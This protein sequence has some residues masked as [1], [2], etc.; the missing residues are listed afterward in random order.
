MTLSKPRNT[1]GEIS[2]D[3]RK[4]DV[5]CITF[6]DDQNPWIFHFFTQNDTFVFRWLKITDCWLKINTAVLVKQRNCNSERKPLIISPSDEG[7]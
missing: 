7:S 4:T 3:L 1:P 5:D 6:T 2:Y